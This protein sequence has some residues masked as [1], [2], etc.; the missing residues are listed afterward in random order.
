MLFKRS[1]KP[2]IPPVEPTPPKPAPSERPFASNSSLYERRS[3][4]DAGPSKVDQQR[5]ELLGGY[6]P[7]KRSK[8]FDEG[9]SKEFPEEG[10]DEDV[11]GIKQQTRILKEEGVTSTRNALR[12]AREAEET[13]RGTLGRL[14]E[15][16]GM[17]IVTGFPDG[18]LYCRE[19]S[20][21]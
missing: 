16:S 5:R 12:F 2:V 8:A 1:N 13:A 17:F 6:D 15:Q 11:E 14:G 9:L 3:V 10:N 21:Y 20:G 19:A 4:P 7:S 18:S